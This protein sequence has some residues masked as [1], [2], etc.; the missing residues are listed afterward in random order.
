MKKVLLSLLVAFAAVAT[1]S[2][3]DFISGGLAYN[4][5]DDGTSV[6][7][8]YVEKAT[9]YSYFDE[10]T[11]IWV[12]GY[13]SA[14]PNISGAITIP[15]TV[16][17]NGTT[18]TVT[19]INQYAF[20]SCAIT[21]I[22]IP[23]TVTAIHNNP[24]EY[25]YDLAEIIV[26]EDNPIYDSRDNCNAIITKQEITVPVYYE[27]NN[28]SGGGYIWNRPN[29]KDEIVVGCKN[30][31][32]PSS[33]T[34]IAEHAFY[35]CKGLTSVV[36]P[37]GL[38]SIKLG[39]FSGCE[40][41][42]QIT[43]PST[44]TE[45]RNTAFANCIA[46]TNIYAYFNPANVTVGNSTWQELSYFENTINLHVYPQYVQWYNQ[47]YADHEGNYNGWGYYE[48]KFNVIG[49]LGVELYL[50][51]SFNAWNQETRVPFTVGNDGKWTV[52]QA[53]EAGGEFK[54]VKIVE[55]QQGI[56]WIGGS[57]A[58]ITQE[59]VEN[60]EEIT[61]MAGFGSNFQIPVAGTW[62]ISVDLEN[63]TMVISGEWNEQTI[64]PAMYIIG[65]FNNWDQETQEAMTAGENNTWTI[66]KTLDAG[67]QFKFRDELG[68]WYGGQDDY[69]VGYFEINKDMVTNSTP[70][71]M[72]DGANF[73]I[74]I[75]G[76][77]TFTVTRGE[78][79]T[80]AISGTWND[81]TPI[82]GDVTGE[83]DVDVSDGNAV[84]NIIL[85][86]NTQD[87]YPGNADVTGE[88]DIDV[89]DVNAIIN[90]ILG[91]TNE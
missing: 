91:K 13:T 1:A 15:S 63:N 76:T 71:T 67:V 8:T 74:P 10:E 81:T 16:M 33:V 78:T 37:E 73:M 88:G 39:A 64:D 68:T 60:G 62:T 83:G 30:T 49:D 23:A 24:F 56:T 9:Y 20:Q 12:E 40:D 25:S 52:T 66:T 3:Y 47:W 41:M 59:Q 90:I 44:L 14:N 87:D 54:L 27:D 4:I 29:P 43:L 86:K 36:L 31:V 84:I 11:E 26:A 28:V 61:I 34:S 70:I 51:G 57:G 35:K 72:I 77:W 17:N 85:N 46:L 45:I 58:Q 21:S 19:A 50:I 5:N 53:M 75:A 32:I 89:S 2:A 7:V 82:V 55:G 22:T 80:L 65:T 6:T 18:Y 69:S 42:A 48:H 38:T 79:M